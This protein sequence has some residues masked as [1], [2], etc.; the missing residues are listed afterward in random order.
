MW[1]YHYRRY[2]AVKK[3]IEW[4][5]YQALFN[6]CGHYPPILSWPT[7]PNVLQS[8]ALLPKGL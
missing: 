5:I 8:T 4:V 1:Q 7:S 3:L 6:M 2:L